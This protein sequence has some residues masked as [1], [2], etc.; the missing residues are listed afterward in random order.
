MVTRC[1]RIGILAL[2]LGACFATAGGCASDPGR[3]RSAGA[4]GGLQQTRSELAAARKQVDQVVAAAAAVQSAQ[5]NLAPAYDTYKKEVAET[6]SKAQDVRKRSVDMQARG[7]E[8]RAKWR[9]EMSKVDNP[10]LKAAAD[11]RAAKVEQKYATITAKAQEVR[12]AY[13]PFIKDIKDLQTY[14]SNDLTPAGVQGARPAFD[15]VRTEGNALNQKLDA[16][17]KELDDVAAT[18]A[19]GTGSGQ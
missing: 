2:S 8:Y 13:E 15:K 19:P 12:T 10:D 3:E 17:Q 14:L 9:A 5:G 1:L 16:L 18:M 4:V 6:E 11:A 7:Q